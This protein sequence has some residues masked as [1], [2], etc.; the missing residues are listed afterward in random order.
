MAT[1]QLLTALRSLKSV[2]LNASRLTTSVVAFCLMMSSVLVF[3]ATWCVVAL[4]RRCAVGLTSAALILRCSDEASTASPSWLGVVVGPA[5][6]NLIVAFMAGR[7]TVLR[8]RASIP[9][10]AASGWGNAAW[11]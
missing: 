11:S 8:M 9:V 10:I 7:S 2:S 3:G 6:A 4:N 5:I 1:D